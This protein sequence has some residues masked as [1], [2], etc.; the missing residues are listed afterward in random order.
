[1]EHV[2]KLKKYIYE[3]Q[4][5][6]VIADI[7]GNF[8]KLISDI[9]TISNC[10]LIIAGDVGIGFQSQIE[11]SENLSRLN[12]KCKTQNIN[13]LLLRGNHDNPKF[14]ND[15]NN[16]YSFSNVKTIPDYS[17]I[18]VDKVNILCIGGAISEDR[19]YRLNRMKN[20]EDNKYEIYWKN[21]NVV[22]DKEI[23]N[24]IQ[25]SKINIDYIITHCGPK[26]AC[27]KEFD[28]YKEWIDDD[29][30]LEKE[31]LKE[32]F[33]LNEILEFLLEN[34]HK[35]KGWFFGHYHYENNMEYKGVKFYSLPQADLYFKCVEL[36]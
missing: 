18:S 6:Y 15:E 10:L 26:C 16:Q 11:T 1:M 32:R 33:Y 24:E 9:E 35:I 23:L 8:K 12:N 3:K 17:I 19:L 30:N 34:G 27:I 5:I 21:E 28:T 31:I 29:V 14:F 4:T 20:N 25:N 2:K 22:Y 7:H 13:I 36:N